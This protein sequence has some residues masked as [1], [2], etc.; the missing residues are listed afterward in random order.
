[1]S[2]EMVVDIVVR[3]FFDESDDSECDYEM[4][5]GALMIAFMLDM[6]VT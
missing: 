3:F 1:M 5:F 2:L 6:I 4:S